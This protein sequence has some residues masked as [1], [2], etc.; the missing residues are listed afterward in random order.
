MVNQLCGFQEIKCH[1]IFDVK[2]DFTR[3]A[4][5]VAGDQMTKMPNSLMYSCQ[6]NIWFVAGAECGPDQQGCV[7]KLVRALYGLKPSGAAWRAMFLE[8]IINV[9]NFKPTR[10]DADVYMRKNFCNG[11]NP[12]YEY[13][14]VSH[15]P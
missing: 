14:L 11:G 10:A 8:F 15:A 4:R 12:Y 13:L 6:E 2:M 5:F 9:M 3:K 7:F 1:I